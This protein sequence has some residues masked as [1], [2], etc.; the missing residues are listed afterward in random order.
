M[1]TI[2]NL[3]TKFKEHL[4]LSQEA[5]QSQKCTYVYM[6]SCGHSTS[7]NNKYVYKRKDTNEY[8]M[9]SS[10]P[11]LKHEIDVAGRFFITLPYETSNIHLIKQLNSSE[12]DYMFA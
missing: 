5:Q 1:T 9:S 3:C 12:I 10:R 6:C 8:F 4:C 7:N 2:N 11:D